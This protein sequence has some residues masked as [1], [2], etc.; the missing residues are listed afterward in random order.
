MVRKLLKSLLQFHL[1][2]PLITLEGLLTLKL[3]DPNFTLEDKEI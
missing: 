2:A 1:I 3:L